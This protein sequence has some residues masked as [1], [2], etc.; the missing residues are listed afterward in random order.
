MTFET[1]L[2][3]YQKAEFVAGPSSA[4]RWT[5]LNSMKKDKMTNDQL[6]AQLQNK[7]YIRFSDC[8]DD[9]PNGDHHG[10]YAT[11]DEAFRVARSADGRGW[12]VA[13]DDTGE[14][15]KNGCGHG[16]GQWHVFQLDLAE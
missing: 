14:S 16:C 4:P 15:E 9:Q 10:D 5:S 13:Y 2:E 11:Q 7:E 1:L 3:G 6:I 12:Y 8:D